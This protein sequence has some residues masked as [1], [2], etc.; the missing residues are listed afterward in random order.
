M[1]FRHRLDEVAGEVAA[2]LLAVMAATA[3]D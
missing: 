3:I 1:R 2:T